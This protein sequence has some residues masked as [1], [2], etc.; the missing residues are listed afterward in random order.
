MGEPTTGGRRTASGT[1]PGTGWRLREIGV[2]P[3]RSF[4]LVSGEQTVG[5]GRGCDVRLDQRGI[6][7]RHAVLTFSETGAC[8]VEDLGSKNGTRVNGRRVERADVAAGD[9]VGFGATAWRL[10]LAPDEDLD[11]AIELE[12]PTGHAAA[13]SR[14]DETQAADE[15]S[16]LPSRLELPAGAVACV[17]EAMVE[18]YRRLALASQGDVPVLLLGETGVGKEHLVRMLHAA[19]DRRSGP[20]VAINCAAMPAELLEAELFGIGKG[21]A[22]GVSP[23]PGKIRQADGGTFFLDEIGDLAPAVQAKLLRVLQEGE[24]TPLGE[25]PSAVDV[26]FVAATHADLP[27]RIEAGSFRADL[28]YRLAGLQL[29]VP[30]LRERRRDLP[31]LVSYFVSR[32]SRETGKA[33]RGVTVG[34]LRRLEGRDWPG[35]VRELENEI[36]RA[37]YGCADGQVIDSS[38][39]ASTPDSRRDPLQRVAAELDL[40]GADLATHLD[41]LERALVARALRESGGN[42]SAAARR[43]GV[44]RNG[45]TMR[46]E[47]LGVET[48]D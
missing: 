22:T 11:L 15:I 37:V 21:V 4:L 1:A 31:G 33:V 19:S 45:L 2:R 39:M 30:P 17:S 47:R 29:R 6:S 44:S 38:A 3:A 40:D 41:S 32:T 23:R 13:T 46:V 48:P 42:R 5:S 9:E 10:E 34:A 18:L 24:V 35:N 25:V 26:R 28:Y 27:A 14:G 20:L 36:R 12:P 8:T 16:P 7:R 43:L